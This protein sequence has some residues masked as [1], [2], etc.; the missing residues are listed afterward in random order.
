M[1]CVPHCTVYVS[2]VLVYTGEGCVEKNQHIGMTHGMLGWCVC[3]GI[4]ACHW[5]SMGAG[6]WVHT[7]VGVCTWLRLCLGGGL[8]KPSAE[9]GSAVPSLVAKSLKSLPFQQQL[10]RRRS[11]SDLGGEGWGGWNKELSGEGGGGGE[12]L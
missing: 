8:G 5:G 1:L 6:F 12:R 3:T 9:L 7:G 2:G 10:S 4:S 11:S